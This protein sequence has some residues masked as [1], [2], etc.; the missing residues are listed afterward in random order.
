MKILPLDVKQQHFKKSFRGFEPMEVKA[1]LEIVAQGL[2]ELIKENNSLRDELRRHINQVNDYREKESTLK[3]TMLTA[4]KIS[5]DIRETAKKEAELI[6]HEAE[7]KSESLIGDAHQRMLKMMDQIQD[8]KID[9]DRFISDV[10]S[11]IERHRILVQAHEEGRL[12][13]QKELNLAYLKSVNK[14]GSV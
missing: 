6:I 12:L 14:Q 4:Q 9:R 1:F 13:E 5:E 2:E 7:L 10:K 8:L 11:L 3:E